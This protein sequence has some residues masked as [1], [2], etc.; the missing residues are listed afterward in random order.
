MT[1]L[2]VDAGLRALIPPLLTNEFEQLEQ[3]VL[4]EGCRDPLVVWDERGV[5]LDGHN[6]YEICRKHGIQFKTV[7]VSHPDDS[8]AKIWIIKNQFGRRNLTPYQRAELALRLDDIVKAEAKKQ[9]GTR[10]DLLENFPKS[11]PNTEPYLFP[12]PN[13]QPLPAP[14]PTP[15]HTDKK[16]AEIAGVSDKQIQKAREI[17]HKASDVVKD[18][19]RRGETSINA[20]HKELRQAEK[21]AQKRHTRSVAWHNEA[22]N[23]IRNSRA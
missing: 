1:E 20:A 3:N 7:N 14:S 5:I 23:P 13:P 6:R 4:S 2:T 15:I 11:E 19:L 12:Q 18:Q 9:Q 22:H 16:L 17:S 8:S 21:A 10:N